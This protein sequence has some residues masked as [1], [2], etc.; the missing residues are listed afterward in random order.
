MESIMRDMEA[1]ILESLIDSEA[2][3]WGLAIAGVYHI[4]EQ[5]IRR[6]LCWILSL[7]WKNVEKDDFTKLCEKT[8]RAGY[9]IRLS[10]HYEE[11]VL[12]NLITNTVKHGRGASQRRLEELRPGFFQHFRGRPSLRVGPVEFD[13]AATAVGG[14]WPEF[15]KAFLARD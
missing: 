8:I 1:D 13:A 5:E 14:I 6:I 3:A 7:S 2:Y 9:D 10:C 15:E 11:L 12:T 4:W